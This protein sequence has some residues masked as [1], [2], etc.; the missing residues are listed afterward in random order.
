MLSILLFIAW[1]PKDQ[2]P[3]I[4]SL[5]KNIFHSYIFLYYNEVAKQDI[6]LRL[7]KKSHKYNEYDS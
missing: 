5:S 1:P 3:V 4:T 2:F 7:L 6:P